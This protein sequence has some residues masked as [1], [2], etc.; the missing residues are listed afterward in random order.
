MRDGILSIF[1]KLAA[2]R[3]VT[4][5]GKMTS[6]HIDTANKKI[7]VSLDLRGE[8]SPIDAEVGYDL[9]EDSG[10]LNIRIMEVKTSRE[11]LTG[12][13]NEALKRFPNGLQVP[14][15]LPSL[16]VKLAGR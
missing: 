11:W 4:P 9:Q 3:Y 15:G 2:A 6:F 12:L 13:A 8:Q 5:Y 1:A 16:F 10:N 7:T 14:P